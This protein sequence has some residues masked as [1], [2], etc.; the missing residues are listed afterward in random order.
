MKKHIHILLIVAFAFLP[1]LAEAC[2]VCGGSF[3][4]GEVSAY[5]NITALLAV[6]PLVMMV[7]LAYWIYKKYKTEEA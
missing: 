1:S 2:A 6:V 3:T 7:A 4:E 5:L